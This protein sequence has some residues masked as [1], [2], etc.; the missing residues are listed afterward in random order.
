MGDSERLAQVAHNLVRNA[1]AHTP[2]G[3]E[4]RVSTGV[5]GPMGYILV[6][7]DGP[8]IADAELPRVFDRFYQ[9]DPSRSVAGTGLGLAIVRAIAEALGGSAEVLST[10]GPGASLRV[11]I[12]LAG[13]AA[14]G[15]SRR[16]PRTWRSS[17][18]RRF[19][20]RSCTDEPG[21]TASS[22][23]ASLT[24]VSAASASGSE[25]ATMPDPARSETP[26]PSACR[27]ALR[28]PIIHSPSPAPSTQPTGPAHGPRASP[29]A[30]EMAARASARGV[31]PTAGVG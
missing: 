26:Q 14:G 17:R 3:T 5:D 9:G 13:G 11:K 15:S 29:S 21:S 4:V 30:R 20:H 12:P 23:V 22:T 10:P 27:S 25:A 6:A 7:D 2:P 24:S 16:S 28:M 19:P 18:A 1:V 8:G 31:P